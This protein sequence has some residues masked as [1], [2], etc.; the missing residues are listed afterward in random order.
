MDEM[1]N[2]ALGQG[3]VSHLMDKVAGINEPFLNC[4]HATHGNPISV[5][6]AGIG[7]DQIFDTKTLLA[8]AELDL[9]IFRILLYRHTAGEEIDAIWKMLSSIHNRPNDIK[10]NVLIVAHVL[11]QSGSTILL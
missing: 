5:R 9:G 6:M 1:V 10:A 8:R 7:L 3:K 4:L 2:E 11:K